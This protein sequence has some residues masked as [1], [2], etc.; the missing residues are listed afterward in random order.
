MKRNNYSSILI[1]KMTANKLIQN[2]NSN[3]IKKIKEALEK[4]G[5]L[6]YKE[7]ITPIFL[8]ID[9][10]KNTEII[11]SA[12]WTL[13]RI[14]SPDQLIKLLDNRNKDIILFTIEALGRM[15]AKEIAGHIRKFLND[16]DAEIRAMATWTAGKIGDIDSYS[17]IIELLKFDKDPEVRSNAAWAL[18]KLNILGSF[19]VLKNISEKETDEMVLY[20][21]NDAIQTLEANYGSIEPI[22]SSKFYHC[23]LETPDCK[24]LKRKTIKFID[25]NISIEILIVDNCDKAKIC[26]LKIKLN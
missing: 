11:D 8:L 1:K 19:E 18:K 7:A 25:Q 5:D 9:S 2:L 24:N 14:A 13:S 22:L 21:I 17:K 3:N 15:E 20:N 16:K 26:S 4:I 12:I 6:N 23:K 10:S